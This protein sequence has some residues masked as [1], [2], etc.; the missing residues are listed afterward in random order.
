MLICEPRCA[1]HGGGGGEEIWSA[2][3]SAQTRQII[4]LIPRR[5]KVR[6]VSVIRSEALLQINAAT[7]RGQLRCCGWT[8]AARFGYRLHISGNRSSARHGTGF[9]NQRERSRR[10]LRLWPRLASLAGAA[11]R[12]SGAGLTASFVFPL[13][14]GRIRAAA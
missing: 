10:T 2:A 11:R 6:A 14:I 13:L 7:Q 1:V 5:R 8:D 9:I 3:T 12:S 4:G